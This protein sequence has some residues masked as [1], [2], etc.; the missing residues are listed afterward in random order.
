V[1]PCG[2]ESDPSVC[3]DYILSTN[4]YRECRRICSDFILSTNALSEMPT[5]MRGVGG[6]GK[7]KSEAE[8]ETEVH[9]DGVCI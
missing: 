9:G 3:S 1:W 2:S 5:N 6:G 4:V 8:T 7:R